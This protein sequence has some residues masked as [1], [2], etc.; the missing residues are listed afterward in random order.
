MKNYSSKSAKGLSYALVAGWFMGD[1]FKTVYYI[2]T[3]SPF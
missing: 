1:A 2:M 3:G